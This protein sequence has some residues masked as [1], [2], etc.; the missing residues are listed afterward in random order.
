MS[1]AYTITGQIADVTAG[2]IYPGRITMD[3]DK[4]VS[5]EHLRNAPERLICPGFIDAHVHV[6]SS[7]LIPAEFAAVAVTHGTVGAVA[8]PHEIA[9]VLG[10]PGVEYMIMNGRQ[11]P[12]YFCWGAPSCVPAT[13]FETA[14]GAVSL[15]DIR[16][17]FGFPEVGFL[18]EMMN[19]PGVIMRDPS[20][21]EKIRAAQSFGKPVDGHAPLLRGDDLSKYIAAGISTDHEAVTLDEAREKIDKGMKILIRE[22][23]AARYLSEL[24][25]LLIDCGD[26]CMF[27]T[28]DIHAGDLMRGHI[29][30]MVKRVTDAGVPLMTALRAACLNP[31]RH[32]GMKAGLLR[33]GDAADLVVVPEKSKMQIEAVYVRGRLVAA[34]GKARIKPDGA[35]VI[36]RFNHRSISGDDIQVPV[37]E[38]LLKVIRVCEGRLIT[39]AELYEPLLDNGLAISDPAR[40]I[41]KAVVVNRYSVKAKPAVAFVRGFGLKH[42]AIAASVGHDSH[43]VTA[44]GADDESLVEA[45]NLVIKNKGALVAVE[46]GEKVVLP[47]PVAGLMSLEEAPNVEKI[48]N[49]LNQAAQAAAS[50]L[51]S[52]FTMM[53]FLPLLV[54][55]KLRLSDKGLFDS[56]N[57]QLTS[58]FAR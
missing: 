18:A 56:E 28:D 24:T 58:L 21:M 4:I 17:L 38:G 13:P 25:P 31:L 36:N 20:V 42:G 6:E 11:M 33:E 30:E 39:D 43:N 45:I 35:P 27:C 26:M 9:N 41:L 52:P 15:Q 49:E 34:D 46:G 51:A 22:G 14:G 50:I 7:L 10:V 53:S 12:F 37:H 57:F 55:P 2:E 16:R 29:N 8:D 1:D 3:G 48:Q 54:I 23:S 47:L 19:Y 44:V 5:V 32:Y 40:D